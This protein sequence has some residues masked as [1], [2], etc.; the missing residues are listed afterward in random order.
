MVKCEG[1]EADWEGCRASG[2]HNYHD[3]LDDHHN[4]YHHNCHNYHDYHAGYHHNYLDDYHHNY[5][6][7]YKLRIVTDNDTCRTDSPWLRVTQ[8]KERRDFRSVG[9]TVKS[10]TKNIYN[11]PQDKNC[12]K[13]IQ[14]HYTGCFFNWYPP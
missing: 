3:Y 4:D 6:Y 9:E 12:A 1:E 2:R 11:S 8:A 5:D 7:N 13:S 10:Q 14:R